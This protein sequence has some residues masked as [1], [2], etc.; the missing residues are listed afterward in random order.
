M[1]QPRSIIEAAQALYA[2][3]PG[4]GRCGNV[5][6]DNKVFYSYSTAVARWYPDENILLASSDRYSKTTALHISDVVRS[7]PA[8][9]AVFYV[10]VPTEPAHMDN[11]NYLVTRIE[12]NIDICVAPRR[13]LHTK[14]QALADAARGLKPFGD[15]YRFANPS[16][17]SS[18]LRRL[19]VI[20]QLLCPT[21]PGA[22]PVSAYLHAD[23]LA[24]LPPDPRAT[25]I[26][27][28]HAIAALEGKSS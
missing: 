17:P 1:P 20:E 4:T 6:F 19:A 26:V 8:G 2:R 9:A 22:P 21:N 10:P 24:L 11:L 12:N 15:Y 3:S 16:L 23:E 7:S 18:M 13:R 14:L 5:R 25:P 28:I 27:K